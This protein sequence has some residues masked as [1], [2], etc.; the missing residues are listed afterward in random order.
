MSRSP[1]KLACPADA[2]L[3]RVPM[4]F[5]SDHEERE[6]EP[7]CTPVKTSRRSVWLRV[8]DPGLAELLD[9]ARHYA[10]PEATG[11]ER[12]LRG[13]ARKTVAAIE[14]ATTP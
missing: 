2:P 14:A 6:C 4:A 3:V 11:G 9:D 8:D 5:F 10:D 13:S 1:K 7:F 12:R